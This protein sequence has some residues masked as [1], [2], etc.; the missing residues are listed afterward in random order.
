MR[1]TKKDGI[2]RLIDSGL[3]Q[4]KK[5][6]VF[7]VLQRRIY[8]ILPQREE[9]VAI[10]EQTGRRFVFRKTAQQIAACIATACARIAFPVFR[11]LISRTPVLSTSMTKLLCYNTDIV[12]SINVFN[13]FTE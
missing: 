10:I 8:S 7:Q 1:H 13:R 12:D 9:L 4:E 3:L 2:N 6:A 11:F 5:P